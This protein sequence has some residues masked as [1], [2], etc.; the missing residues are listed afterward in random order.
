MDIYDSIDGEFRVLASLGKGLTAKVLKANHTKSNTDVAIKIYKPRKDITILE[1]QFE[2]EVTTMKKINHLNVL[3]II[4]ANNEGVYNYANGKKN[5]SIIYL[6]LEVCSN[7]DFFDY[8]KDPVKGFSDKIARFYFQQIIEGLTHIHNEGICHRDLKTENMFLDDKFNVKIGDFGFAKFLTEQNKGQMNTHL[9][10][11]G[12][13]S[14]QLL[15]G[16]SYDGFSN[17]IFSCGVILFILFAGSPPF[18]E[19]KR[20]D[21]WYRNFIVGTIDKFWGFHLQNKKFSSSL[22]TLLTEMLSENNR[23]TLEDIKKS[24][25]YNEEVATREEVIEEMLERK[26][27]VDY[28]RVKAIKI[29]EIDSDNSSGSGRGNSRNFRGGEKTNDL[30]SLDKCFECLEIEEDF[31]G[32]WK[33]ENTESKYYI[34]CNAKL[35]TVYRDLA[36]YLTIKYDDIN[37]GLNTGRLEMNLTYQNPKFKEE[38]EDNYK[39]TSEVFNLNDIGTI[40]V[41]VQVLKDKEGSVIQFYKNEEMHHFDFNTFFNTV[42]KEITK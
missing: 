3:R 35:S 39:D 37:L 21:P 27:I 13:Q 38:N 23:Y 20:S 34:K 42:R 15:S 9:G 12:Y 25:W 32:E 5:K 29:V 18:K 7:G 14:P 30:E 4:A 6:C 26:K 16:N 8:I 10:T 31:I 11:K 33:T 24:K 19:A 22:M 28:E 2:N 41:S 17:D 40:N 36:Y 1:K